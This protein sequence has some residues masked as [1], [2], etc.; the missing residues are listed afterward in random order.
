[1]VSLVLGWCGTVWLVDDEL[2]DV[3]T[4]VVADRIELAAGDGELVEVEGDDEHPGLTDQRPGE[5]PSGGVNH[6]GVAGVYEPV[7]VA[8]EDVID[9]GQRAW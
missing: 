2:E 3:G 1:V 9:A 5:Q 7:L 6:H 8:A 4:G